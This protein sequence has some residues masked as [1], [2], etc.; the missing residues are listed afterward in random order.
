MGRGLWVMVAQI[1]AQQACQLKPDREKGHVRCGAAL[2]AMGDLAKVCVSHKHFP[3]C[4]AVAFVRR[5][6]LLD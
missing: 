2:E 3:G 6:A 5:F 4:L 1:D